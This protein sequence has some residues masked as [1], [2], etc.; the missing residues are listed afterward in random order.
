MPKSDASARSS[1]HITASAPCAS[2]SGANGCR[3]RNAGQV[4][5]RV[6][7][8]R[9][10]LHRAR[11]ERIE[12]R[13]DAERLLREPRE[14][15]HDVELAVVGQRQIVAQ[16]A[17][18]ASSVRAAG[19]VGD[20][21]SRGPLAVSKISGRVRRGQRHEPE[22]PQSAATRR[23]M[24]A[25]RRELGRGHQ[26]AVVEFGIEA[27]EIEAAEDLLRS[28]APR[29]RRPRGRG[30]ASTNSLNNGA[31]KRSR[32]PSSAST[33]CASSRARATLSAAQSR[34][35]VLPIAAR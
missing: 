17:V 20:S 35:P 4:R 2:S 26:D 9:V 7:D 10:V 31:P 23:S 28:A 22:S 18:R 33:A 29:A 34:S 21:G 19:R 8:A 27:P 16:R 14:V 13:V 30:R 15:A 32:K 3:S 12:R 11:A 24:S 25:L 6:V 5:H 1:S